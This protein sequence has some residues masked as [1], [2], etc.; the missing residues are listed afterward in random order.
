MS[1][2]YSN[3][4]QLFYVKKKKSKQKTTV[5]VI[6]KFQCQ[7]ELVAESGSVV[8]VLSNLLFV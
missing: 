7:V 3:N 5:L 8:Y 4:N 1:W 6:A 2:A